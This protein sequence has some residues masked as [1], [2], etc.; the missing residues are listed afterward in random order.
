MK[1]IVAA[2]N[3]KYIHT[4]LSLRLLKAYAEDEFEIDMAEYTIKDPVLHIAA[5]L[6]N[7]KPDVVGFSCY[8]WNIEATLA[9][10]R[11]LKQVLPDVR[12]VLGDRRY[13]ST[14]AIFLGGSRPS[15]LS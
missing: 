1:T 14:R 15:I 2:I 10:T 8:I 5:D 7:R 11:I 12:I 9:V 13:P 6:Y 3:A 4:A